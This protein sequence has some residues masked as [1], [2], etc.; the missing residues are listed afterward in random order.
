MQWHR[1]GGSNACILVDGIFCLGIATLCGG[2]LCRRI[3]EVV[4]ADFHTAPCESHE[5][6]LLNPDERSI[7]Q[8]DREYRF[9]NSSIYSRKIVSLEDDGVELIT[10]R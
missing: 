1:L 4:M 7:D 3:C 6:L 2:R 8:V 10:S 9:L 5:P